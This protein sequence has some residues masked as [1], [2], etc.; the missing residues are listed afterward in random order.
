M[1]KKLVKTVRIPLREPTTRKEENIQQA[2][3]ETQNIQSQVSEW[4]WS[5]PKYNWDKATTI[6]TWYGWISS[7]KGKIN[8]DL[9]AQSAQEAVQR[10]RESFLSYKSNGYNGSLPKFE[11]SHIVHF[12]NQ[13]VSYNDTA[14]AV[15]LPFKSGRG[16]KEWLPLHIGDYQK[17]YLEEYLDDKWK[18]G[19]AK[20]I[21]KDERYE[22]HQTIKKKIDLVE[23]PDYIV[24]VDLGRNNVASVGI[25]DKDGDKVT[26]L[27]PI[28]GRELEE[29]RNTLNRIRKARQKGNNNVHDKMSS[30]ERDY[31]NQKNHEY[32]KQIINQIRDRLGK[33]AAYKVAMEDLTGIRDNVTE[34][35]QQGKYRNRKEIRLINSWPYSDFKDKLEYKVLEDAHTEIETVDSAYTSQICSDCGS[36]N[37]V[38]NSTRFKCKDC[39]YEGNADVN[40][41]FNIARRS[42]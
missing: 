2:M 28:K 42:L 3:E 39:G 35:H 5:V 32:T 25:I 21:D 24:G 18:L 15:N 22:L 20:L 41:T 10:V 11:R 14:S 1:A 29:H 27:P 34:K 40:A 4:M 6:N 8:H 19:S 38:R 9:P 12:H 26:A 37:T 30:G 23:K 16:H 7:S 33:F 13:Q 36:K 17:E 31:V